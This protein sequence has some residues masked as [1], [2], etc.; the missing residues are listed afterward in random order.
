MSKKDEF[1]LFE[2]TNSSNS[3][4]C[5]NGDTAFR[6]FQELEDFLLK[7][8]ENDKHQVTTP[9]LLPPA[10]LQPTGGTGEVSN[11]CSAVG[12]QR[13][14]EAAGD[15]RPGC[16]PLRPQGGHVHLEKL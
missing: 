14:T 1:S 8:S 16:L 7:I 2:E 3:N 13:T 4:T 15:L 10:M 9:G 6:N 5:I 11:S 12:D